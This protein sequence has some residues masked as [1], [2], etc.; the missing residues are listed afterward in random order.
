MADA[1]RSRISERDNFE[2]LHYA[3]Q[4]DDYLLN[5][6]RER[7]PARR[8]VPAS[9]E[10]GAPL[11]LHLSFQRNW[12]AYDES[13]EALSASN[14]PDQDLAMQ[15]FR[16]RL[17]EQW[18]NCRRNDYVNVQ[19]VANITL[20]AGTTA[21][22]QA[23]LLERSMIY[24]ILLDTADSDP[25]LQVARL[26]ENLIDVERKTST[27]RAAH[28][29]LGAADEFLA[30]GDFI[31]ARRFFQT[32]VDLG[33][34]ALPEPER[35]LRAARTGSA[36]SAANLF[37]EIQ[38]NEASWKERYKDQPASARRSAEENW[39]RGLLADYKKILSENGRESVVRLFAALPKTFSSDEVQAFNIVVRRAGA[40]QVP[41]VSP[42]R[43]V[44]TAVAILKDRALAAE[45][46][47]MLADLA[48]YE[49]EYRNFL[50]AR[51]LGRAPDD[52]AVL[53][54]M[55][56]ELFAKL[57]AGQEFVVFA[58]TAEAAVRITYR[59]RALQGVVLKTSGRYLRGRLN[60]FLI[61]R[62]TGRAADDLREEL[63]RIY[64]S[65]FGL[66]QTG[67]TYYWLPGIHALAP[68]APERGD[69]LFQILNPRV[70]LRNDRA[71]VV[72]G[73]EFFE[74]FGVRP[75]GTEP[76]GSRAEQLYGSEERALFFQRLARMERLSLGNASDL[77]AD[78]RHLQMP[79][80]PDRPVDLSGVSKTA[81]GAWFFSGNRLILDPETE[82]DNFNYLLYSLGE[83]LQGPGVMTLRSPDAV[84]HAYFVRDYY[85]RTLPGSE[86]HRRYLAAIFNLRRETGMSGDYGY[87]LM[88]ASFLRGETR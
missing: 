87:R 40:Q 3:V 48:F 20:Q 47:R 44:L 81:T 68:L 16:R 36:L 23:T 38:N 10:P 33:P 79:V 45:D 28:M 1:S 21:Y 56:R 43:E 74:G 70:M 55:A 8:T 41:A 58:D 60:D 19:D 53:Q 64:R 66:G 31:T 6:A 82:V 65:L 73:S 37:E 72:S 83:H 15:K 17:F 76:A 13:L 32:Y 12:Q 62:R 78:P 84:G 11:L 69:R 88:T 75:I 42:D 54:P 18:A 5:P 35:E 27:S 51:R 67:T 25:E 26:L 50:S 29:A 2:A 63:S 34:A 9:E 46:W 85:S 30:G 14:R 57:P 86:I 77:P 49:Q 39:R 80:F 52:V 22:T 7:E 4:A 59:D 24:R 61:R 71:A